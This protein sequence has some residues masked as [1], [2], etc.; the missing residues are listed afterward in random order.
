MSLSFEV[1]VRPSLKIGASFCLVLAFTFK[2]LLQGEEFL[3]WGWF[4]GS[5]NPSWSSCGSSVEVLS[6]SAQLL[7]QLWVSIGVGV[8]TYIAFSRET[9]CEGEILTWWK[10]NRDGERE[11]P[12]KRDRM[13]ERKGD[14]PKESETD[15]KKVRLT[16]RNKD[17]ERHWLKERITREKSG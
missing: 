9:H 13:I 15:Q 1:G 12:T 4:R 16:E 10:A 2:V 7:T 5:R 3:G 11:R 6:A 8:S 17:W 14:W